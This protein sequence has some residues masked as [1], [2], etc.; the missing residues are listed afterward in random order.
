[1]TSCSLLRALSIAFLV[2]ACRGSSD[3]PSPTTDASTPPGSGSGIQGAWTLVDY[4]SANG[5]PA[6]NPPGVFLF[7]GTQYSIMYSN[8]ANARPTFA[9][10]TAP[11][12]SEK[13]S[14]FDTF[15]ANSGSYDLIGDT[16]TVHPVISK[17]PNY[18]GGGEDKFAV[19]ISGDTL[20]LTN[21]AGAF[22]WAGGKASADTTTAVDNFTLVRVR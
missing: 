6:T 12:N 13:V 4:K 15:I 11:T 18:M 9:D 2:V 7:S 14:A 3:S 5:S 17:N 10:A 16:L 1:M 8:Q 19:R 20:W 22:R 21:I